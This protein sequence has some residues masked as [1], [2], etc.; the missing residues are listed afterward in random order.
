VRIHIPPLRERQQD[1][2]ELCDYLLKRIT[3]S[4]EFKVD[5]SEMKRLME[6]SWPG[7]VRE[8]KN[9]LERAYILQKGKTFRPSELLLKGSV[10][11]SA[12]HERANEDAVVSLEEI[13]KRHI[14]HALERLSGNYTRAAKA[15][16]ISLSTLKRKSKD[17]G[18]K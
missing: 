4:Q 12:D 16:G 6:Y 15:L 11:N 1:I 5:D 7:N 3:Y 10:N 9:I 8:L 14:K 2:P 13:E 18:L 17:Y